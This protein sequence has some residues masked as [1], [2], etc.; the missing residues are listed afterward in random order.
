M[1]T[2]F[3]RMKRVFVFRDFS[4]DLVDRIPGLKT[5]HENQLNATNRTDC[6]VN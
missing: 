3:A 2:S 1:L 6:K 5:I 4:C